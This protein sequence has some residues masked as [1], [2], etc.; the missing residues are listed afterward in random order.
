ML[1]NTRETPILST[2]EKEEEEK[3]WGGEK[4]EMKEKGNERKKT[5]KGREGAASITGTESR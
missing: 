2:E 4:G 1:P 5:E 3:G